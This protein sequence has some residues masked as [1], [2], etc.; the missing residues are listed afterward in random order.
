MATYIFDD[1][2]V[3]TETAPVRTAQYNLILGTAA[4]DSVT[5]GT[6]LTD[7]T[8][9]LMFNWNLLWTESNGSFTAISAEIDFFVTDD[10]TYLNLNTD[11]SATIEGFIMSARSRAIVSN[12]WVQAL[13]NGELTVTYANVLGNADSADTVISGAGGDVI[14]ADY[15]LDENIELIETVG[16]FA[17]GAIIDFGITA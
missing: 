2:S 17:G 13:Q 12:E 15:R 7:V 8:N 5:L 16:V 1:I 11:R 9:L 14:L 4:S 3:A 6:D 10:H